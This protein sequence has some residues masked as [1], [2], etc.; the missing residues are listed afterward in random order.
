MFDYLPYDRMSGQ[1]RGIRFEET[2]YGNELDYVDIH[3]TFDGVQVD[4]SDVTRQ[5]LAIRNSTIHNCQGNALGVVNSNVF[6]ENCQL[7][8]AL[9]NCLSVDGGN[10][11]VN[12]STIAQF[13]PFDAL[14]ASALGFS[15]YAHPLV[16]FK[17]TNSIVTGYSDDEMMGL[18]PAVGSEN[19]FNY[20][21][22]NCIIRTP[23]VEDKEKAHYTDVVFED[24]KDTV[25]YGYKHFLL[26]DANM[27]R[28]D[29]HLR[30]ESAAIDKANAETSAKCDHDGRERGDKPDVGAYENVTNKE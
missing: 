6:V 4:S 26:V 30:K 22:A 29:F 9:G 10:V 1:W 18:K 7:T 8:N 21:F 15:G 2:S 27:Q 11:T 16:S 24:V 19:A 20:D 3:G 28:Y 13:Y 5:T 14:R 17:M 25:S 23:E 12:S